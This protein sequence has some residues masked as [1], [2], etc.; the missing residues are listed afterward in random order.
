MMKNTIY[1]FIFSVCA[2]IFLGGC[3][4]D[5]RLVHLD[6]GHPAPAQ[7][8]DIVV[9]ATPGGAVITYKLPNDQHLSYVKATY[10]IQPGIVRETK[11]SRYY[12]TLRLEGFG[13][14][15]TQEVKIFSVGKNEKAS[16][17]V[18]L[19]FT[20]L[21]PPVVS[22]FETID[23]DATF[24]GVRVSF[25]NESQANIAIVVMVDSSGL[26]TWAP[27]ATFFT[28]SEQATY[29]ARGLDDV[30]KK[31]ALFV[32]DRWGNFSDTLFK[33]IKPLYE[34]FIPK[35]GFQLVRLPTDTWQHTF[36]YNIER[37][38]DGITNN[39][40]N[41][42]IV[43]ASH[44]VPQWFTVDL[45]LSATLSRMK[46]YQRA[47]YPYI[48]PMIKEFEIY[49][50]NNPGAN[51]GWEN[52]ELLGTFTSVKPS[53]LPFGSTTTEDIQ[54]AVINGEDFDFDGTMTVPVRYIRFKTL[55]T[56]AEGGGVQTS[57]ISFWGQ[58][59]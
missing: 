2:V 53:G 6:D 12:D 1:N 46:V 17:P 8:T 3:T 14:T 27:L 10:Q 42:W 43:S 44:P 22:V 26:N 45:G 55:G 4:E 37:I 30:E 15:A 39:S 28:S 34:E 58:V 16:E 48:A 29:A 5:E 41:V 59:H 31:F 25:E 21:T 24:G 40:E 20:P 47:N 54:Y 51:G 33:T 13:N 23:L 18:V 56:W 32:R 35:N 19:N 36:N 57:E 52:W 7:I 49:G 50:S 38:W 9:E 11:A